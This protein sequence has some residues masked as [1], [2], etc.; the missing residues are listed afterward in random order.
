MDQVSY[1]APTSLDGL[2]QRALIV[3]AAGLLATAAGAFVNTGQFFHSYLLAY[4]FVL[5]AA[6]GSLALLMLHHLSGGAWG[7]V[8]RRIFEAGAGTLPWMALFFVPVL[9]G[10]QTLYPWSRPSV[11]AG[12]HVLE[13]KAAYLNVPFF[14][15]RAGIYFAIWIALARLLTRWSARQ[16]RTGDPDAAARM[17][18]LA[19]PGLVLYAVTMT[20]AS[21]DWAM[22]LEPHWFSTMYG[23][24]F[25]AGQGLTGLA[26]AIIVARRLSLEAPMDK[27]Y[28]A[29][30]FHDFG[31][32]LFAFTMLWAYLSFSQFLIIWAGNLPEEIPWFQHRLDHGWEAVGLALVMLHFA[33]PFLVLL[34]R[35]TKRNP[36]LLSRVAMWLILMRFVDLFFLIGPEAY[37]TG[38]TLGWM[39]VVAPIGLGSLWVSLFLANLKSRPL[40]P[41]RDPEF[42]SA[43]QARG[44]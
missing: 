14:V 7:I 43:L 11:V 24:L 23:F 33:V 25:L 26:L 39:D 37:P 13:A 42:A 15:I 40:L 16:D 36:Y 21:F 2:R 28:N 30:H 12:D 31:K 34:S 32:L 4:L 17:R 22:S 38:L 9:F 18:R 8:T 3:G 1:T 44:H 29:G 41:V 5:A 10:M 19:A 35:R 27:V 20:F 6:L